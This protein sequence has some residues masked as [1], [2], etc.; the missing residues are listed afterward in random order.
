MTEPR[1]GPEAGFSLLRPLAVLA[2]CLGLVAAGYASS[3][4]R[5]GAPAAE[6]PGA[7]VAGA[8]YDFFGGAGELGTPE[9]KIS[10]LAVFSNVALH[11]KDNYVDPA[12]I[13][14]KEMLKAALHAIEED[15]AEVL[16]E[17]TGP[18]RVRITV[19]G[20]SME[21]DV[22]DVDSLWEINLKLRG[23]FR[24]L[25]KQLPARDD[26]SSI[27][28]AAANGALSTLDPH[29]VLLKP[30]AFKDMKTSTKGEFGGLG[31]VISIRDS[32]L[33]VISPM[34]GTPA[35]RAGIKAG[36]VISR[37]GAVSTV[38][39]PV[40]EAVDLLRGPEGSKVTVWIDRKGWKRARRFV[41]KRERIR[42]QSVEGK[43]LK[44]AVAYIRVKS[45]SRDTAAQLEHELNRLAG[46]AKLRGLVLD[47]RGNP[48][49]LMEQAIR[50]ADKFLKSGDIVTTVGY[51]DRVRE[52]KRAHF[53]GTRDKLPLAVLLNQG[54]ASASEIV[55]GALKN[56]DRAVVIGERSFGKGSVQVLYDFP[57]ESALKLTIAQYLTPGGVSIQGEG[58][59]PDIALRPMWVT[60]DA[61]RLFYEPE[62]QREQDLSKHLERAEQST[63]P[64]KRSRYTLHYLLDPD[65]DPH[66]AAGA[67]IED[68]PI[69]FSRAL[70][71]AAGRPSRSATLKAAGALVDKEQRRTE[72]ELTA[73]LK[74]RGV[75]WSPPPAGATAEAQELQVSLTKL[76]PGDPHRVKAG[77][78]L[79]LK[80]TVKNLGDAPVYRIRGALESEHPAF[81]GQELVFGKIEPGA[82]RAWIVDAELPTT[83]TARSDMIRL[84]LSEGD[85]P[86]KAQAELPL[87]TEQVKHP[88]LA[89]SYTIDD[90]ER[91]DGDGVLERGEGAELVVWVTNLGA[92]STE[93]LQLHLRSG[94]GSDLFMERGRVKVK[95]TAPGQTRA[96]RLRFKVPTTQDKGGKLPLEL[97]IYDSGS[98]EWLE[99]EITLNAAPKDKIESR[100]QRGGVTLKDKTWLYASSAEGAPV[101]GE[102]KAGAH[103]SAL[104]EARGRV[105]LKL[106]EGVEVWADKAALKSLSRAPE[107]PGAAHIIPMR[108]APQIELE[109]ALGG[110][111]VKTESIELKGKI[112]ARSLRDM[113]VLL[114]NQKVF[115]QAAPPSEGA[116][117]LPPKEAAA[118]LSFRVPLKLKLGLNKIVIVARIDKRVM[119]LRRLMIT[120]TPD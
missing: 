45:F 81:K 110:G 90:S 43:L 71:L 59:A 87:V 20:K 60:E 99:D 4:L 68:F 74:R 67:L 69:R 62:A 50:I 9:Y 120:R 19:L 98:G 112:R 22:S 7:M 119:R 23:I 53:S 36:D 26:M 42:I 97:T 96:G 80:A 94:A 32:K 111:V 5:A 85:T 70:L 100:P 102:A 24:F 46:E 78:K 72:T 10:S 11:L 82:S 28:Y 84:K 38:S 51:G 41:L 91:G 16:V 49:G 117:T 57:N 31:I 34:R 1:R 40:D 33:T 75:D 13:H 114:N 21:V 44:G 104:R 77:A 61:L 37:I 92:G 39:M 88:Q 30:D 18:D 29:S 63:G 15:V 47:L 12:R 105:L 48:G 95:P 27:E 8:G 116:Q 54:S 73:A 25:E 76:G 66:P 93:E 3:H 56:L 115:Y 101:V 118:Q 103:F 14:P 55:A 108:S 79:K 64:S 106:N 83:A 89:Y 65:K 86:L 2:V 6:L 107:Q 52:A 109:G 58:I 17:D 35:S 113:Y